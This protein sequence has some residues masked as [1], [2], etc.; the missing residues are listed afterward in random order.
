MSDIVDIGIVHGDTSYI[1]K[2]GMLMLLI[3]LGGAICSIVANYLSAKISVAFSKNLRSEVFTHVSNFSLEE[4]EKLGTASLITRTTNDIYQVQQVLY[5]IL[6]I[7]V[8]APLMCVGG[9]IMAISKDAVLSLILVVIIPILVISVGYVANKGIPLFKVM[10]IRLDKLNLILRE[11]LTGLR[12]IR[13]FN[14]VE[15]EKQRFDHSNQDFTDTAI[16]VHRI[17]SALLP[18]MMLVLNFSTIAII[19]F[20]AIRIN[21]GTMQVGALM[22][23]LQYAMQILFSLIMLSMIFV[24]LP[25]AV[26]SLERINQVLDMTPAISDLPTGSLPPQLEGYVEFNQVT[27]HYP[28]ATE[29]ALTNI[30]FVA[31]PGA[32]TA[33]IGGTGAGKST[34]VNLLMGFYN[35]TSGSITID[36]LDIRSLHQPDLRCRIGFIPQKAVLF[37]GTIA[38]NIAYGKQAATPQEIAQAAEIAQASEFIFEKAEGFASPI[39]QGGTNI[40]GGQKQRLA[41]ARALVREAKIYIFDDSFSALD[42]TTEGKLRTALKQEMT[43]VTMIMV[44]QRVSTIIDADQIIVLDEGRIAGKG[45]HFDLLTTCKVYRE[46]VATQLS[47]EETA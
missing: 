30:S 27:F 47:V 19:W 5:M 34:L 39:T 14:R 32:I 18:I 10:Q 9:I 45:T 43:D 8:S 22:A 41:I 1:L 21:N 26:A 36:G 23:F 37:S 3:A 40:S 11:G 12:V 20:G 29:P 44:A 24:L 16:T 38:D 6:R 42:F 2:I 31:R 13:S 4:F 7:M 33:I 25:R 15:Y 35:V 46:I 17:M 28:G